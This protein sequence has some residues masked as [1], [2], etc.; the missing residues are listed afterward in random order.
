MSDEEGAYTRKEGP[1][2]RR[3]CYD[4]LARL[5]RERRQACRRGSFVDLP[6]LARLDASASSQSSG[7]W[8]YAVEDIDSL[9]RGHVERALAFRAAAR[10]S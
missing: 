9:R 5:D 7:L 3:A 2:I 6:E 8:N 1:A 4:L 10:Q